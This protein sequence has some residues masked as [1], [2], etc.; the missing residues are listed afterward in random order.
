MLLKSSPTNLITLNFLSRK[1]AGSI[2]AE[3]GTPVFV[4]DEARLLEQARSALAFKAPFGLTVRYAMKANPLR[5][6]LQTFNAAG[7]H[8]DASSGYE[9][10]RAVLA[11][12]P[13]DHIMVTSQELPSN[14]REL[15]SQGVLFNATSLH[16]LATYGKLFPGTE[17]SIR[18]NP[19]IGSGHNRK[20][21]TGGPSAG[22]GI[23]HEELEDASA[24]LS[25]HRLK[26]T[27]LHTHIGAGTNPEAWT[28]AA[29]LTLDIAR[30]LPGISTINL[31]GGF[32]IARMPNEHATDISLAGEA[33][34]AAIT[35]FHLETGRRLHLEIEPG[36]FMVA[37]AGSLISQVQDISHTGEQGFTFLKLDTGLTEIMRPSLYG[38]QHPII[39]IGSS[40]K[41]TREYVVIGHTCETGDLLTPKPGHTDIPDARVLEEASIGDLVV[42]EGTGAY[43]ASMS[44]TGYNS[45]PTAPEVLLRAS[46]ET[47]LVK[48]PQTLDQQVAGEL[49]LE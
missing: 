17:I 32:K 8:I 40:S 27:K 35:D 45:F 46:G 28:L 12:I 10:T 30:K 7:I 34:S 9:A 16:Q 3:Y 48:R 42:I 47:K 13:A 33:I 1:Q 49:E 22:F 24:I 26:L 23:W 39:V 21:N 41:V 29:G 4:Y 19:G 43:C 15:V 31:G 11:G 14:L 38:S 18:V 25:R 5:A 44:A 20:T 6:I 2:A 37:N 36:T